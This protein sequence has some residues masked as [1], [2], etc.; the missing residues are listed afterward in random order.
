MTAIGAEA[1]TAH[2]AG[3]PA[4]FGALRN[5]KLDAARRDLERGRAI[6]DLDENDAATAPASRPRRSD[7]DRN[8]NQDAISLVLANMKRS[9][10]SLAIGLAKA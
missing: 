1:S 6:A 5:F 4:G 9:R 3:R 7:G 2:E 10:S 8:P